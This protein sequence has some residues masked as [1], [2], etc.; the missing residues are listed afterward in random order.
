[1]AACSYAKYDT[2]L[3]MIVSEMTYLSSSQLLKF[4]KALEAIKKHD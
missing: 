1:M 3:S 2:I 4:S